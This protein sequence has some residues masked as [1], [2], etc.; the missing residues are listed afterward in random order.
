M[1]ICAPHD[2]TR[3]APKRPRNHNT[4]ETPV[5]QDAVAFKGKIQEF[6]TTTT[7]YEEHSHSPSAVLALAH[8]ITGSFRYRLASPAAGLSFPFQKLN[9]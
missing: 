7:N 1:E 4:H 2:P 9:A 6:M 8:W 5:L 3:R